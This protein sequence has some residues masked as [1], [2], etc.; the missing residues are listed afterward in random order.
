MITVFE[1]KVNN[2]DKIKLFIKSEMKLTFCVGFDILMYR[3]NLGIKTDGFAKLFGK[4]D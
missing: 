3:Y 2:I 1:K 4:T